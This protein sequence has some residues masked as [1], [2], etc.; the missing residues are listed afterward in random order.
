MQQLRYG[1]FEGQF[2]LSYPVNIGTWHLVVDAF[3][4]T[5][6]R[7]FQV[8][9][10]YYRRFEVNCSAPIEI[11]DTASVYAG[12]IYGQ[13]GTLMP[14]SGNAT[15]TLQC[16][17]END[18]TLPGSL[19]ID[20][21]YLH[22]YYEFEFSM[23]DIL[24]LWPDLAGKTLFLETWM[25]D[26]EFGEAMNGTFVTKVFPDT[27]AVRRL[28][29][30]F[31]SFHPNK[32]FMTY[33][34]MQRSNGEPYDSPENRT[35]TL[36][37]EHVGPDAM[38]TSVDVLLPD[39]SIIKFKVTPQQ[40]DEKLIIKAYHPQSGS[41]AQYTAYRYYSQNGHYLSLTTPSTTMSQTNTYIVFTVRT[42]FFTTEAFYIVTANNEVQIANQLTMNSQQKTFSVALSRSMVPRAHVVVYA[43]VEG[44]VI[45]DGMTFFVRDSKITN[46]SLVANF[47]KDLIGDTVEF[48]GYDRKGAFMFLG[49]EQWEWYRRGANTHITEK[50]VLEDLWGYDEPN[51]APYQQMWYHNNPS[52]DSS[53]FFLAETNGL[54]P[55]STLW[56]SGLLVMTDM[57]VSFAQGEEIVC[58]ATQGLGMCM[59]GSCYELAKRCDGFPDCP[60]G[61]DEA[62]CPV[63]DPPRNK[64]SAENSVAGFYQLFEDATWAFGTRY[65]NPRSYKANNDGVDG[66]TELTLGMP[67]SNNF[68]VVHAFFMHPTDGMSISQNTIETGTTS[69]MFANCEA[70]ATIRRGEQVG[71]RCAIFSYWDQHMEAMITLHG[72]DDYEFVIV[73]E[74]GIVSSY[75]PRTSH[76]DVQVMLSL[77]AGDIFYIYFPILA[78]TSILD[79]GGSEFTVGIS[80]FANVLRDH[81]EITFQLLYDGVAN[82]DYTPYLVDLFY[83]PSLYTPYLQISVPEQWWQ[84]EDRELLYIPGSNS[85]SVNVY[86]DVVAPGFFQDYFTLD[87]ITGMPHD[88][89]NGYIFDFAYNLA[90][91]RYLFAVNELDA[92]AQEKALDYMQNILMRQYTYLNEDG[93]FKIVR[94]SNVSCVW[95]TSY[96]LDTLHDMFI[97]EWAEKV[98]VPL[99]ILNKMA[100]WLT[101]QQQPDGTFV[102]TADHVYNRWFAPE[103]IDREGN[104]HTWHVPTTAHVTITLAKATRI[105]GEAKSAAS[106]AVTLA[107]EYLA[108]KAAHLADSFQMAITS[109]ALQKS[110]NSYKDEAFLIL[111]TMSRQDTVDSHP[112][113]CTWELE[114]N[115]YDIVDNKYML[116]SRPDFPNLSNAVMATSYAMLLYLDH[117]MFEESR[118]IMKWI[119]NSHQS[120]LCFASDLD[121]LLGVRAL[122]E[123]AKRETNHQFYNMAIDIKATSSPDWHETARI[124]ASSFPLYY[125]Y[126]VPQAWGEVVTYGQGTGFAFLSMGSTYYVEKP[127]Q[128]YQPTHGIDSFVMTIDDVRF[129]G[130]N[131]SMLDIKSCATWSQPNYGNT[132]GMVRY[133]VE[134]PTGFIVDRNE[135]ER[136]Y[137]AQVPGLLRVRFRDKGMGNAVIFIFDH[138]D[139]KVKTCVSF[140]ARRWFPV[141]NTSINHFIGVREYG[142]PGWFNETG[143]TTYTLFNL[144]IC[145]SCGSFQCS[146]C[147]WYNAAPPII[148]MSYLGIILCT[149]A[150]V[151]LSLLSPSLSRLTQQPG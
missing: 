72:S 61:Y 145:K 148:M 1:V 77:F 11:F 146:Y 149:S 143:Y 125:S 101:K 129:Y 147:P 86:G 126:N 73:E 131:A 13:H 70:P 118:P 17:D 106:T 12:S 36:E 134:M 114:S 94:R 27:V 100:L 90:L 99:D 51:Q 97:T 37:V 122:T 49:C 41:E 64:P 82:G 139:V 140:T 124:N 136:I 93:S 8:R 16:W 75:T 56:S 110:G 85:A 135:I 50:K 4:Y 54:D 98:Y 68:Y 20:I 48:L 28:G 29:N 34:A 151:L 128:V 14:A 142:E 76:G 22:G 138:V 2:E 3:G 121:T 132:S 32:P 6:E 130:R 24:D 91:M 57:R 15:V 116:L 102:E 87:D 92:D 117:G 69:T 21:P 65:V 59:D 31:M 55:Y 26:W 30:D 60:D 81:D 113:W 80:S 58:N 141:A 123:Y 115:P 52:W 103:S 137:Q 105:T 42:N 18:E 133:M 150:S 5:Y 83:N 112:Y 9:F 39:D 66:M 53:V 107:S 19:E 109:Y 33:F 43:M 78:S 62:A 7:P 10:Y 67:T 120:D 96:V 35:L 104:N 108:T 40:S 111:Q 79:A 74:Y 38:T 44:E 46:A 144:D 63:L 119:V 23:N 95:L 25:Y 71:I 45:M 84:P 88:T 127:W 89:A 47:G